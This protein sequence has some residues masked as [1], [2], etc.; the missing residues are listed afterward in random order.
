MDVC[1]V[2]KLKAR[3]DT[4]SC[5]FLFIRKKLGIEGIYL[6]REL[7]TKYRIEMKIENLTESRKK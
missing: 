2:A 5:F 7:V 1:G 6:N 3:L 4:F